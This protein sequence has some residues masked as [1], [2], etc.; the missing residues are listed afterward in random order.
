M[1]QQKRMDALWRVAGDI[2]LDDRRLT[3]EA[4]GVGAALLV[5]GQPFGALVGRIVGDGIAVEEANAERVGGDRHTVGALVALDARTR[6]AVEGQTTRHWDEPG[7]GALVVVPFTAGNA[8]Y[9][10]VLRSPQPASRPFTPDDDAFAEG[11]AS[12]IASRIQHKW[13]AVRER[14][15]LEIVTLSGEER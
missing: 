2:A 10:L 9:A 1:L 8:L 12:V 3:Y 14:D 7:A 4:L 15:P 11:V 13:D 5:P 6:I